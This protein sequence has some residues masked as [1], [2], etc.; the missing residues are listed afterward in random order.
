MNGEGTW[1]P[2]RVPRV[3]KRWLLLRVSLSFLVSALSLVLVLELF[4]GLGSLDNRL[5]AVW[6]VIVLAV[7]QVVLWPVFIWVFLRLFYMVSAGFMCLAFPAFSLLLTTLLTMGASALYPDFVINGFGAAFLIA[8]LLTIASMI[9]ASIFSIEDEPVI[10]HGI[11]RAMGRRAVSAEDIGR[12]GLIF[13][14]IDGLGENILRQAIA[15]GKMANL[16][17]WL[18]SGSHRLVGWVSD[19]SSQTSAAQAGILHGNNFDIPAFRWYDKVGK[20]LVV[21]SS[22]RDLTELEKKLTDG[23]GLLRSGGAVRGC[24]LSGDASQALMTASRVFNETS[25]ELSA[26]YLNPFGVLRSLS[27]MAW[28]IIL[29]KKSAWLQWLRNEQPRVN[30]GGVYF[31]FRALL[32]VV[33]KDVALATLRGDM[34][35]GRPCAY[36]SL[37]GYDEVAHHSG[38]RS[39]DAFEILRKLDRE[40][41]KLEWIAWYAPRRYRFVI[42]SDH[43]QSEGRTFQDRYGERLE[44]LVSRL[45]NHKGR[46]LGVAGYTTRHESAYYIDAALGHSGMVSPGVG[47]QLR[48]ALENSKQIRV[49]KGAEEDVVV[50]ASGNLGLISFTFV[51]QRLTLEEIASMCPELVSG[52]VEHPGIGFVMAR[53]MEKGPVVLGRN[54]RIYLDS[55]LVEGESPLTD[56]GPHATSL[57]LREDSFPNA[58]DIL[59]VSTYWSETDEVAAFEEQLCSHG[60]IGGEQ[61]RPFILYPSELDPGTDA[62]VG[63]EQVY[64]VFKRWIAEF[65]S[66]GSLSE[67]HTAAKAATGFRRQGNVH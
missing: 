21:S 7:L 38:V 41:G 26:Y 25:A 37:A 62:L 3:G 9:I 17:R 63:A 1:T 61:S 11:L 49:G 8:L 39:R 47:M 6:V 31:L 42:L 13:I 55:G 27:L 50:L 19:L 24:L 12:P 52:L 20:K 10:Y 59:V 30:R 32:A 48:G 5:G 15:R 2:A 46:Q 64:W 14:E 45:L 56:Y 60:G 67:E 29:E 66:P 40:L 34:Y 44:D 28:D 16:K 43:G 53:S 18:D 54:G 22:T 57:L 35:S 65:V 36:V 23:N 58:P 33:V 4:P 51:D